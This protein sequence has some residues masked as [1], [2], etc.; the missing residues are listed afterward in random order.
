VGDG[1]SGGRW[2]H[3]DQ[4][5]G[6]HA[7]RGRRSG[8]SRRATVTEYDAEPAFGNVVYFSSN[9]TQASVGGIARGMVRVGTPVAKVDSFAACDPNSDGTLT[10]RYWSIRTGNRA[11]PRI[12]GWIP[13]A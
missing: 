11:R 3:D 7:R 2:R 9:T 13:G 5:P 1:G 12:Y 6:N 4:R 8:R 10:W